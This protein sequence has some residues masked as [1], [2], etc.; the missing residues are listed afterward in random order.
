MSRYFFD[1]DDGEQADQ[2]KI[3]ISFSNADLA[4]AEAL[5]A[6]TDMA[7]DVMP[8]GN[9]RRFSVHVRDREGNGIFEAKL[10]LRAKW[11]SGEK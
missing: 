3:G 11:L 4:R 8:D 5:R 1:T 2:D 6:L 7:R 10:T 9:E